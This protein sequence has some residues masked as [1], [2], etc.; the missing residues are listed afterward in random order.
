MSNIR[1][2]WQLK[3]AG[4]FRY[5]KGFIIGR[6]KAAMYEE[7]ILDHREAFMCMIIDL[8]VPVIIDADIGHINPSMPIINGSLAEVI[9]KGNKM[10]IKMYKI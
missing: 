6:P 10:N 1:A 3:N 7:D 2:M 5:V 9:C 4:W 8:N